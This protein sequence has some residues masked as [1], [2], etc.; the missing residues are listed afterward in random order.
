MNVGFLNGYVM[1]VHRQQTSLRHPT[2]PLARSPTGICRDDD[3]GKTF[4]VHPETGKYA[5]ASD[6]G[7]PPTPSAARFNCSTRRQLDFSHKQLQ[8]SDWLE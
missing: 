8:T 2:H 4:L 7:G 1:V 3:T 5:E 6:A